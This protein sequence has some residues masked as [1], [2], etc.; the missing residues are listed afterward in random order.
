MLDLQKKR[1]EWGKKK[2]GVTTQLASTIVSMKLQLV[3][4]LGK[5]EQRLTIK[6]KKALLVVACIIAASY[7]AFVATS[8]LLQSNIRPLPDLRPDSIAVPGLPPWRRGQLPQPDSGPRG[9]TAPHP[10]FIVKFKTNI[11]EN[12]VCKIAEATK[13]F[14]STARAGSALPDPDLLGTWPRQNDHGA[15]PAELRFEYRASGSKSWRCRFR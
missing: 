8:A 13:V 7:L 15:T 1:K 14:F 12:T 5:W 6:Q 3:R 2:E 4:L 11:Y 10:M 9:L